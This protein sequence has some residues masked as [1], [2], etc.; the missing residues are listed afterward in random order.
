MGQIWTNHPSQDPQAL[1]EP[2]FGGDPSNKSGFNQS[3]RPIIPC[4]KTENVKRYISLDLV[5]S[6][7]TVVSAAVC[8]ISRAASLRR[9]GGL[10]GNNTAC[11][12]TSSRRPESLQGHDPQLRLQL[13]SAHVLPPALVFTLHRF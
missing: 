2:T 12:F 5:L 13:S 7:H 6:E 11:L 3:F 1:Y 8:L 4:R 9:A 10:I